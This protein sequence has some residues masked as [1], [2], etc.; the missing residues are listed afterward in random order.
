MFSSPVTVKKI[1]RSGE[2][3]R[4]RAET[5]EKRRARGRLVGLLTGGWRGARQPSAGPV[6][7]A[8][9]PSLPQQVRFRRRRAAPS[10]KHRP[11]MPS[12]GGERTAVR[13][14]A[15]GFRLRRRRVSMT[16]DRSGTGSDGSGKTWI[17]PVE[18][19]FGVCRERG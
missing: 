14:A 2:T 9:R 1:G 12:P 16:S 18:I 10:G 15:Y 13:D 19:L 7:P 8:A 3:L 4:P 5:R 11:T 6:S 17:K